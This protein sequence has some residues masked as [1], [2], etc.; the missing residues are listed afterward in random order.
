MEANH[1]YKLEVTCITT[2]S[3]LPVQLC[4]EP[5]WML[6]CVVLGDM[7]SIIDSVA[8]NCLVYGFFASHDIKIDC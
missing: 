7:W 4:N 1:Y 3:I 2:L 8:D 6:A 5:Q